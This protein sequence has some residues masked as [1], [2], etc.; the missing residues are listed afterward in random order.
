M[1]LSNHERA[2]RCR[3]A[4]MVYSDDDLYTNLVDFLAD[5]MHFCQFYRHSFRDV[6]RTAMMHFEAEH[7]QPREIINPEQLPTMP[8]LVV[9]SVRGGLVQDARSN[10]SIAVIVEDWD[11]PERA[12]PV[13]YDFEPNSLEAGEVSRLIEKFNLEPQGGGL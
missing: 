13:T 6:L 5:A 7:P 4:V 2:A 3:E 9:V 1:T 10:V 8:S 11:C 12:A